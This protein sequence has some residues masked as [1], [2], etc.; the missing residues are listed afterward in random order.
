M[1]MGTYPLGKSVLHP[2]WP[3]A[4]F[5][6]SGAFTLHPLVLK[7]HDFVREGF[8]WRVPIEAIHGAPSMLWNGGRISKVRPTPAQFHAMLQAFHAVG[9]GY[10]PTFTSHLI[11][12]ADLSDR[13]GNDILDAIAQRPDLNAVIVCSDRLS[14]HIARRHPA[15]RQVASIVKV[16]LE[17]GNG[18]VDYY[19]ELGKRFYRY[20]V[21]PDDCRDLKLLD[22]LDRDKA[23][24]IVNENCIS[25]CP[26]R[27]RHYETTAR[28]QRMSLFNRGM[29][30]AM[31]SLSGQEQHV[32][33][34]ETQIRMAC[35]APLDKAGLQ[36]RRRSCNLT[37]AEM[38][39]IYDMGFRHFKLAGRG[40]YEF[41]YLYDLTRF[42][43][44]PEFAAPA[45]CKTMTRLIYGHGD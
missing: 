40:N 25:Q 2:D 26:N 27:V 20:V 8:G 5:N 3:E 45:V 43:L 34:E 1:I 7:F 16:T 33:K 4:H 32:V 38:K 37:A 28:L 10:F 42:M 29:D 41:N 6:V 23:E 15:L 13:I 14:Q 30:T 9:I 19:R 39:A 31:A 35:Q 17:R 18:R 36:V 12:E 11:Q 24:I 22:Q 21:H 44:E